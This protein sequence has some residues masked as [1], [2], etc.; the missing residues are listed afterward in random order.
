QRTV[1]QCEKH[2]I[3]S[4]AFTRAAQFHLAD[5]YRLTTLKKRYLGQPKNENELVEK[6]S[7]KLFTAPNRMSNVIIKIGKAN[8]H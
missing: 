6:P 8:I 7:P 3:H 2:V 1:D 4:K 5:Q